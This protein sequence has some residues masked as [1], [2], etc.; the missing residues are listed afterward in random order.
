LTVFEFFY[1]S[2]QQASE[3]G[4]SWASEIKEELNF[5]FKCYGSSKVISMSVIRKYYKKSFNGYYINLD[6]EETPWI[7]LCVLSIGIK[8]LCFKRGED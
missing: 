2:K 1:G 4:T 3:L 7:K 6:C 5:A 8:E